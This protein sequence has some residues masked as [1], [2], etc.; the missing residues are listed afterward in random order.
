MTPT[1]HRLREALHARAASVPAA[2]DARQERTTARLVP[3]VVGTLVAALV[4]ATI[5]IGAHSRH[6]GPEIRPAELASSS[7][8]AAWSSTRQLDFSQLAAGALPETPVVETVTRTYVGQPVRVIV[9]MHGEQ[10][11]STWQPL[12]SRRVSNVSCQGPARPQRT[13]PTGIMTGP[14]PVIDA[15]GRDVQ[16]VAGSVALDVRD[17]FGVTSTGQRLPATIYGRGVLPVGYFV[18]DIPTGVALEKTVVVDKSGIEF[19]E[20]ISP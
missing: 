14:S 13:Q 1:E 11:C 7:A 12:T 6:S 17:V 2:F 18:Y 9:W 8:T 4:A 20:N 10:L 16:S 15:S 5:A 19:A 3:V